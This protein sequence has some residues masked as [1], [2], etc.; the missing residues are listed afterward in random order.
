[1]TIVAIHQPGYLPWLGFF[2][3][4]MNCDIFV[5]LDN[6]NFVKNNYYNRNHIRIS[7]GIT[8]LTVP[9]IKGKESKIK[10]IKIDNTKNWAKKHK[11]SI[12]FNYSKAEFFNEIKNFFEEL[13]EKN[14]ELLI[15]LNMEIIEF[16]KK[17]LE[18]KTRTI[19]S[20]ELKIKTSSA[21]RILDICKTLDADH[22]ISGTVWA[23]NHL[24]IN[25]FKNQG[26]HIKFQ[27]FQ[28]PVYK[29][30]QRDFIPNMS[31]IDLLFNEGIK[32]SRKIL[33]KSQTT[34]PNY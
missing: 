11:K 16:I 21:Q 25:D 29:Q 22:Y 18:I 10:E 1:M 30:Y 27:E 5:Y 7:N 8:W 12:L 3:K 24:N 26:I 2:K 31:I 20:S 15:D 13:Y 6:A 19:F 32:N 33:I 4:M 28:H 34:E 14:F 17:Q 23:K 9:V